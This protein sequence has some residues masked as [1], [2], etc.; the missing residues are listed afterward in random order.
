MENLKNVAIS[1]DLPRDLSVKLGKRILD[2]SLEGIHETKAALIVRYVK[3]G[4]EREAKEK[5][6]S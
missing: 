4:V 2:L 3:E 5:D 1:L 6:A